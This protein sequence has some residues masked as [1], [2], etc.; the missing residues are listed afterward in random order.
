[1]DV[2]NFMAV[3][4]KDNKVIILQPPQ[5]ALTKLE[6]LEFAAW[7][8]VNAD[9]CEPLVDDSPCFEDYREA[10]LAT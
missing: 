6:A 4:L 7:I 9:C 8:V 5:R 3:G 10:I 1:M 2:T